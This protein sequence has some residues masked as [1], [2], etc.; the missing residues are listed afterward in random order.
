MHYH[1][2]AGQ[3]YNR[4][5][6]LLPSQAEIFS[7]F[8]RGKTE[9]NDAGTSR[10]Y[11]APTSS[12]ENTAE[13]HSPRASR[14][15]GDY[16]V[17]NGRPMPYRRT[18]EGIAIVTSVGEFVN[19]GAWVG[20]SSGLISY[21]GFTYQMRMAA[22]DDR[23]RAIILDQESPGARSR[24]SSR[25]WRWSTACRRPPPMRSPPARAAS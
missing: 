20:A 6:L 11:F 9:E 24:R 1:R 8:P 21:E 25:W 16:P 22:A 5:L 3:F 4:P 13:F 12:G 23:T 7:V 14:F 18:A 19:R 15:Y 10:Q 2:I 17:E